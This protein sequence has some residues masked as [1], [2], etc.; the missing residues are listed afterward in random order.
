MRTRIL[1]IALL[2]ILFIGAYTSTQA[3][4]VKTVV[5]LT[6][7]V[8]DHTTKEPV[9]TEITITDETGKVINSTRSNAA[10]N[11]YYYVTSLFPGQTYYVNFSDK[12]YLKDRIQIQIPVTDR[13]VELSRDFTVKQMQLNTKLPFPVPPYELNRSHLRFGADEILSDIAS[14]LAQNPN[15]D[16]EIVCFPDNANNSS[17]NKELTTKRAESIRDYL[18]IK[19]VNPNRITV[20][21]S[22]S[23]DTINPPPT[24]KRAKGKRYVGP[25]YINITAIR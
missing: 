8:I 4:L 7:S 24:G 11:G 9:T 19:G 12:K 18:S 15:V 14:T 16:F 23:V 13:Y 3:Q 1:S 21:G 20:R 25:A 2:A 10:E 17:A 6:G 5:A 22:E